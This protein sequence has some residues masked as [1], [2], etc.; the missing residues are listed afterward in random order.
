MTN[1][2]RPRA[3]LC[4][5]VRAMNDQ[6]HKTEGGGGGFTIFMRTVLYTRDQL[7]VTSLGLNS[8]AALILCARVATI[9]AV[10]TIPL[11]EPTP[12]ACVQ[13]M[14][15]T[16]SITS[17]NNRRGMTARQMTPLTKV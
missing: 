7:S 6:C 4:Y 17:A 10:F 1:Q 2:H 16:N 14:H 15:I 12:V 5:A 8:S 9:D 3:V 13:T 11:V